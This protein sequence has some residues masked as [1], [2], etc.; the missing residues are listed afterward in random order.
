MT[1]DRPFDHDHVLDLALRPAQPWDEHGP[2]YPLPSFLR[3]VLIPHLHPGRPVLSVSITLFPEADLQDTLHQC[4]PALF[5][6]TPSTGPYHLTVT[7][8]PAHATEGDVVVIPHATS[9]S[10]I[11]DV[12]EG[13]E[14]TVVVIDAKGRTA[15]SVVRTVQSGP[16][17]CL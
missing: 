8:S 1:V 9:A 6:W 14:V 12:P 3:H 7:T 10:W 17:H 15:E 4:T 2:A 11:V 5:A 13:R 16:S